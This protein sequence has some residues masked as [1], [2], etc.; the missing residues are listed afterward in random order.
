MGGMQHHAQLTPSQLRA[1]AAVA[2]CDPR[3]ANRRFVGLPVRPS[4]A[5]RIE[6]AAV[7][8]GIELP[9]AEP[10]AVHSREPEAVR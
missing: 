6:R 5:E 4:L 1:L 7:Q 2:E 9:A 8:L 10:L 3:S